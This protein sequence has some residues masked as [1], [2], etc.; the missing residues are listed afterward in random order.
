MKTKL[1]SMTEQELEDAL[2]VNAARQRPHTVEEF[3]LIV[4]WARQVRVDFSLLEMAV[5]GNTR[6]QV[7]DGEIKFGAGKPPRGWKPGPA[8]R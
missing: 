6:I 3:A 8:P 4:N 2:M 1:D 5:S 7:H